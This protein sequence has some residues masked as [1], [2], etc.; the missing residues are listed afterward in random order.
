MAGQEVNDC[1]DVIR[2]VQRMLWDHEQ[3]QKDLKD[4]KS[5]RVDVQRIKWTVAGGV[6]LLLAENSGLLRSLGKMMIGAQ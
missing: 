5:L 6:G 1:E 2:C 3:M 4:F